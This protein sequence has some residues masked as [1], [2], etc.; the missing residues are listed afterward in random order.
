MDISTL[1]IAAVCGTLGLAAHLG[2]FIRGEH[3]LSSPRLFVS[4][5][6]TPWISTLALVHYGGSTP[7]EALQMV[8]VA[9]VSFLG[10]LF[11]S[12]LVYRA[13]FHPLR[14]YPGPRWA[15]LT[16]F[17][18]MLRI[19]RKPDNFLYLHSLHRQYGPYVRVGPNY[20]SVADPAFVEAIHSPQS[21]YT[22]AEWYDIGYP[23]SFSLHQMRDGALHA[24]RRRHGWDM[25]FTTRSLRCYDARVVKY[26]DKLAAQLGKRDGR[27]VDATEW[28]QLY[29]F[30][31]MGDLAFGRSF[32]ALDLARPHFYMSALHAAQLRATA[33]Q[34]L[35]W[36]V[37]LS[38]LLPARLNP[39]A[40][41]LLYSRECIE[42]RRRRRPA[43]P[44]VMSYILEQ[45]P[46]FG[47]K[48]RDDDLLLADTR[49]LIVA[50]SDT[51]ATSLVY[52]FYNL[53]RDGRVQRA[54]RAELLEKSEA[55]ATVGGD[56]LGDFSIAGL[57]NLPYLNAVI[58]ETL[59]LH[60][61]VPGGVLRNTPAE[62]AV[63][64]GRRLPG[65]V[66]VVSP[67]YTIQRSP[68]A[69]LKPDEF[70]PERWTTEPH[71][72]L[73]KTAFFPFS[74]GK[75][76]CIGRQ[77]ALNELRTAIAK[78]ILEFDVALAPGETGKR[79][80]EESVD[81]FTMANAKL[82]LCFTSRT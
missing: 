69:F 8:A 17:Y 56:G 14:H 10:A 7:T 31:I 58:N 57:Q 53:A 34:T 30:D 75:F 79:L 72:I 29:A 32:A 46:F 43:E 80:L 21:H 42:D 55:K 36:L 74:M 27:A 11:S 62:G 18:H 65:G 51:T 20:L 3:N 38:G 60:P 33:L 77:L 81:A 68:E 50:G 16:Q 13:W 70:R 12:M 24:R 22:K 73:D 41:M 44:D 40:R 48:R 15:G 64:G 4:G 54:L 45:G 82:E 2:Y 61:P 66:T 25:A 26:T 76:A 37:Q 49:L 63:V 52:A 47:D 39:L 6:A 28:F 19:N 78:L 23:V 1:E 59:R 35:P 5:L 71:L 9:S 67:H